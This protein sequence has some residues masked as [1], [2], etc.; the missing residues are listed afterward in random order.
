MDLDDGIKYNKLKAAILMK[1]GI[2]AE[3]YRQRFHSLDVHPSES[4]K[5]QY[6]R[7]KELY[8]KWIRPGE[9]TVEEVG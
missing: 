1:Y 4:P 3:A 7:L 5:E 2:S 8:V 9:K 6:I